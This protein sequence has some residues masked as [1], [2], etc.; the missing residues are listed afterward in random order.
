MFVRKKANRSGTISIVVVRKTYEKFIEVKKFGVVK[1]EEEAD[2]SLY[3]TKDRGTC[4]HK[5][6][7]VQNV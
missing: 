5:F 4:L 6:H 1:S 2:V 7:C 3:G